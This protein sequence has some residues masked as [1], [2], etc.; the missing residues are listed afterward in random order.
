MY[1]SMRE[2]F[3]NCDNFLTVSRYYQFLQLIQQTL[4]LRM[5]KSDIEILN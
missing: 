5:K 3:S 4:Q 2:N 1:L